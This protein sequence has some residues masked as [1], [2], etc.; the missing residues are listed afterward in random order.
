MIPKDDLELGQLHLLEMD[1]QI[2]ILA[3][4][5]LC[6]MITSTDVL[7]SWAIPPLG[8]KCDVV[9]SRLNQ[10]FIFIKQ[11]IY[12]GQCSE[13]CGTN[14]AFMHALEYIGQLLSLFWFNRTFSNMANLG[15]SYP[16]SYHSNIMARAIGKS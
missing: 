1:N 15:A 10:T 13:I 16:K 4:I 3:R 11:G 6:M 14:H 5:H 8:V 9:P 12:Y 2:V 7:H